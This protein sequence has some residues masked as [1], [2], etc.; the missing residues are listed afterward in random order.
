MNDIDARDKDDNIALLVVGN[1]AM[2]ESI[3][4]KI[5]ELLLNEGADINAIDKSGNNILMK[6]CLSTGTSLMRINNF[7]RDVEFLIRK[8][9]D[10]FATTHGGL[11]M[12]DVVYD[13]ASLSENLIGLLRGEIT[14]PRVKGAVGLKTINAA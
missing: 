10:V 2:Y 13:P 7:E 5:V 14:M 8:G 12:L 4:I 1:V 9:A 3:N 11:Q 6:Y